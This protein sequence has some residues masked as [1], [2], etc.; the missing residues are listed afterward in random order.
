MLIGA[1]GETH[2]VPRLATPGGALPFSVGIAAKAGR[3]IGLGD[4][5]LDVDDEA[6]HAD[7]APP[8][9]PQE[10]A[11][12]HELPSRPVGV[13]ISGHPS[14]P[15]H[16]MRGL[17][18]IEHTKAHTDRLSAGVRTRLTGRGGLVACSYLRLRPGAHMP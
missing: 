4:L 11:S 9:A 10:I 2:R 7:T 13:V 14:P 1:I 6:C 3:I 17:T 12:F 5:Q 16:T 18:T 8:C 15:S